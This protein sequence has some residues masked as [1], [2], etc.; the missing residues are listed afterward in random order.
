MGD[1][2]GWGV[3]GLGFDPSPHYIDS[4]F[5]HLIISRGLILLLTVMSIMFNPLTSTVSIWVHL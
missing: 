5:V 4:S 1:V 3:E 2:G